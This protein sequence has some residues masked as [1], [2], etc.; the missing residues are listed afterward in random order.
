[1]RILII[2]ALFMSLGALAVV[3]S[4]ES[5]AFPES[6]KEL[7][8][9]LQS[10][11]NIA[12]LVGAALIIG[13]AV[14]P[15]PSDPTIFALGLIYGGLLGGLIGGTA[16]S[17]AGLMGY[18]ICRLLGE[19]GARLLVGEKDLA[20]ARLFYE[21]WGFAAI[22]LGRAIGGPAEYL[23]IVAGLTPMPFT[24]VLGAILT[25]AYSAAF[26]MSFLGVYALT[27]PYLALLAAIGVVVGLMGLFKAI[28]SRQ[29]AA[30]AE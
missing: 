19:R 9:L 28:D 15:L 29:S 6:V 7:Q 13:D 16:A 14:L 30:S 8:T 12:W 20:R 4:G 11:A 5:L 26:C 3:L 23:V 18:G 22:A 24:R 10:H 25:G 1:M 2:P 27:Q 21:R 17:I